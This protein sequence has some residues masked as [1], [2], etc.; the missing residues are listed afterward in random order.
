MWQHPRSL[1][2]AQ[3]RLDAHIALATA[4][5]PSVPDFEADA[6]AAAAAGARGGAPTARPVWHGPREAT[7]RDSLGRT[8]KDWGVAGPPRK[9]GAKWVARQKEAEPYNRRV[10]GLTNVLANDAVE[11]A[12]EGA[13]PRRRGPPLKEP[14]LGQRVQQAWGSPRDHADL[15]EETWE[16]VDTSARRKPAREPSH[17]PRSDRMRPTVQLPPL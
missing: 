13:Q 6:A 10:G 5:Q 8:G 17:L 2:D 15:Q 12:L 16:V 7:P 1:P 11:A 3:Q 9:D 4:R 14:G